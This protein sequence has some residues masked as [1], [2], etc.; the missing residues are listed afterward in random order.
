MKDTGN[1]S[2]KVINR[3][4][5][6]FL[7]F[8]FFQTP[9]WSM[10]EEIRVMSRNLFL[11]AEIQQIASAN[12]IEE[13]L[14]GA[15]KALEQVAANDFTERANALAAEIVEKKPHLIG[16]QEVY[17][18]TVNGFNGPLPFRDYLTDLL[19]ALEARNAVYRLAAEV[20]NLDITLSIPGVGL[21]GIID[22]DVILARG[23]VNTEVVNFPG[24][25]ESLDGCNYSV[26]ASAD[27]PAGTINIKRGFM[28]VD[29]L[30]GT[31]P[32]RFCNTH[33]EVKNVD[34]LDPLSPYIQ[35]AQAFELITFLNLLPNDQSVP[36][37]LVA[38]INSS[39]EHPII[40]MGLF[41][42]IPPYR[43]FKEAGYV[44]VWTLRNGNPAGFTCCQAENLLNPE[45]ILYE[46]V[47]VIFASEF[48]INQ[49]KAN[50]VGNDAED[51]TTSG[52]WPSDH[53]GVTAHVEFAR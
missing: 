35:S 31:S 17:N 6:N 14:S 23:D 4:L 15:Q 18:F 28:A 52:L 3:W 7:T 32:V 27:S 25:R 26:F 49:V 29:A 12:T 43:Q 1:I 16:L 36:V 38:D 19:D 41:K 50:T 53:A 13:F 2:A 5:I 34:P 45:S 44:D 51:K 40:D 30:I 11:G 42:I 39:P 48:P 9:V 47:D 24:C 21:V 46:R 10:A 33:L 37:I 22:Y 20:K 8:L